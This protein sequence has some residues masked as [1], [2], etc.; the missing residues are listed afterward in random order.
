M[1]SS[2]AAAVIAFSKKAVEVA[3]YGTAHR[4]AM[5]ALASGTGAW[6]RAAAGGK[7]ARKRG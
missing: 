5:L 6:R 3:H 2:N 1:S 7:L 4:I